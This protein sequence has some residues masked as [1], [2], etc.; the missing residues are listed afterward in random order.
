MPAKSS[1]MDTVPTSVIKTCAETFSTLIARLAVL[2]F[3]EGKFP[4]RFK[5]AVV[6]P[7]LKKEGL[8]DEVFANYRPISN[9]N[10][11]SKIVERLFMSRLVDHVKQSPNYNRLQSAYRRGHSTE[12]A[13]LKLLNDVY[14]AA[15]NGFRTAL[16]QLDL[17]AAFDTI[18]INTMLRRLRY[19]FGI[20]GPALNWIASYTNGRTQSVYVGQQRSSPVGHQTRAWCLT[21]IC[22][23]TVAVH[24]VRVVS[25]SRDRFFRCQPRTI[26]SCTSR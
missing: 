5:Q 24:A 21:G 15:D 6:T 1:P 2:S 7:L 20:S 19:A 11:M 18:D 16:I 25:R 26:R 22:V 10:T 14:S 3:K 4:T 23:G 17:S 9:L 12:T 8:D 13:L